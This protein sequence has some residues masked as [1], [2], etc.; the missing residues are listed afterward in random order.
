LLLPLSGL[1][2][3]LLQPLLPQEPS[4]LVLLPEQP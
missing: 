4:L 2:L 1:R 3:L